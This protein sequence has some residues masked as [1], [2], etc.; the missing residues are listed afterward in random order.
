MTAHRNRTVSCLGAA[1]VVVLAAMGLV[2]APAHARPACMPTGIAATS[3]GAHRH[4]L[5]GVHGWTGKPGQM[6]ATLDAITRAMPNTFD[7]IAFDYSNANT[8][9]AADPRV[10]QCL[11]TFV[12]AVSDKQRAAGGDGR[13]FVVAHS[14]GGL[15]T[16]FATDVRYAVDQPV[17]P[18]VLGGVVSFDTPYLGSPF[19]NTAAGSAKQALDEFWDAL[20][21]KRLMPDRSS[22]AVRCLA[23][24]DQ[25]RPLPSGCAYPPFLPSG[26]PVGQIGGDIT[27][28]RTLFG[29]KL[30]D[31]PLRSDGV[32]STDSSTGYLS[33]GPPGSTPPR[34]SF[35]FQDIACTTTTDRTLDAVR[36]LVG[37][38]NIVAGI[39]KTQLLAIGQL[40]LDSRILDQ[41][42]ADDPRAELMVT[43]LAAAISDSGCTHTNILTEPRAIAAAVTFLKKQIQTPAAAPPEEEILRPFATAGGAA[44]GWHVAPTAAGTNVVDCRYPSAS[45]ASKSPGIQF[46]APSAAD[47]DACYF[48]RGSAD[49]LC[50]QDPF[51]TTIFPVRASGPVTYNL[52]PPATPRPLGLLLDDGTRCRLRNG[53]SWSAQAQHPDY[54]GYYGCRKEG[55]DATL[56][57]WADRDSDGGIDRSGTGWTVQVGDES[58]PLTT[59]YVRKVFY[60]GTA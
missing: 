60:V 47:A 4:P 53:G 48:P 15:A 23:V 33:S 10:A 55:S 28:S 6:T 43:L 40:G 19:G 42:L 52:P 7:P 13:V 9:W 22:D 32:V 41:V 46:C 8:D 17:K 50:L 58:G 49:G 18:G 35:G 26:V 27:L 16:R 3:F 56:I 2:P 20:T 36:T 57:V 59:R 34:G 44:A 54:V 30:Y 38:P 31:V 29:Q 25:T 45:P 12:D 24:H 1:L 37:S 5:V 39:I 11:A 14:M 21:A 51:T